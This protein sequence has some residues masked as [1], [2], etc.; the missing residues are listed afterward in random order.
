MT[1]IHGI[2][3]FASGGVEGIQSTQRDWSPYVAH[4]TSYRAMHQIRNAI[5]SNRSPIEVAD[6]LEEADTESFDV[7]E[8]I[9]EEAIL[10]TNHPAGHH[11]I[12][13]CLCLSECTLPGLISMSERYGRFGFVFRKSDLFALGVRPCIYVDRDVYGLIANNWRGEPSSTIGGR[14]WGLSNVYCPPNLGQIQDYTH[15]REWRS[16]SPINLASTPPCFMVAPDAY[17]TRSRDLWRSDGLVFPLD[18]LYKWGA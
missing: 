12:P 9:L 15:E 17:V 2:A 1:L 14:L 5:M 10:R 3:A 11:D 16:F 7:I 8:A 13:P 4:F 6:L 18:V